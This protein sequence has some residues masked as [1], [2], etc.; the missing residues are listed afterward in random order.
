MV[1]YVDTGDDGESHG[2]NDEEQPLDAS[3]DHHPVPH[4]DGGFAFRKLPEMSKNF[5]LSYLSLKIKLE[6]FSLESF[7]RQK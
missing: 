3:R 4:D 7:F 6:R 1:L 5:F 2:V